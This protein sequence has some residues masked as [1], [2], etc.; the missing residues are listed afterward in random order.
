MNDDDD[1]DDFSIKKSN[2][3]KNKLECTSFHLILFF[4]E[5]IR[6]KYI[7]NIYQI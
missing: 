7:Y 3:I 1:D 6:D 2:R 4:C 5:R